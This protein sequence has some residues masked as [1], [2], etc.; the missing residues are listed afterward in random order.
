MK[1]RSTDSKFPN[2]TNE[3]LRIAAEMFIYLNKCPDPKDPLNDWIQFYDDLFGRKSPYQLILTLNRMIKRN[4]HA[5]KKDI[6]VVEKLFKR[7]SI[8]FPLNYE[9]IQSSLR[10]HGEFK[11]SSAISYQQDNNMN[12]GRKGY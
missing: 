9:N 7:A 8:L 5:N 12:L 3:N 4:M 2:M 1:I 6:V 11:N 10:I